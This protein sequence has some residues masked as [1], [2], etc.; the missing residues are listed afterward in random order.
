MDYTRAC[1]AP[2]SM[3]FSRQGYWSRLPS[4]SPGDLPNPGTELTSPASQTDSLPSEPPGR[5]F[6]LGGPQLPFLTLFWQPVSYVGVVGWRACPGWDLSVAGTLCV[7][8]PCFSLFP[9]PLRF[10]ALFTGRYGPCLDSVQG[11]KGGRVGAT[12]ESDL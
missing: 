3:G 10:S 11:N 5:P 4:S 8:Q 9:G 1:Q 2:L 12:S 7:C 6:A